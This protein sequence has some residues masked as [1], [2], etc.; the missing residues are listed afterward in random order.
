MAERSLFVELPEDYEEMRGITGDV[1]GR[2]LRSTCGARD[3][4]AL[5]EKL[6]TS[7][8]KP[9]GFCQGRSS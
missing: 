2:L 9:L 3:A 5:W 6:V 1:V 4:A 8:M 7:K